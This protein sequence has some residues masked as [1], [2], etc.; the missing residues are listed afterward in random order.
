MTNTSWRGG[1]ETGALIRA[2]DWSTTCRWRMGWPYN[3][4]GVWR[5]AAYPG[6]G[7]TV[8]LWLPISFEALHGDARPAGAGFTI[9]RGI[10]PHVDDEELVRM[11]TADMLN[12]L[13]YEVVVAG[14][15]PISWS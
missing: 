6:G 5:S 1:G 10:A 13:G 9:A 11:S 4:A 2:K 7:A 12:G 3:L 8:D 14:S 15:P